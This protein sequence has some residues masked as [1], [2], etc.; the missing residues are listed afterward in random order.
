MKRFVAVVLLLLLPRTAFA[1]TPPLEAVPPG[2]DVIVAVKKGDTA[3]LAGQLFDQATALRW[4]NYLQQCKLRLVADV[5][6]QRKIDE[7][8]LDYL[9]QIIDLEA[10]KYTEVTSDYQARL[11]AAESEGL[12]PPFYKTVWFGITIG[13]VSTVLLTI[14]S[15]YL[16]SLATK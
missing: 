15:A 1:Q 16:I 4:G 11:K 6:L 12:N 9:K 3:P 10:K 2:D 8:K 13:V 5:D 14:G 7:A